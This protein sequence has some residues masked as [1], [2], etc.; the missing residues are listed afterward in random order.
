MLKKMFMFQILLSYFFILVLIIYNL[1]LFL[2]KEFSKRLILIN[3]SL[4]NLFRIL[5]TLVFVQWDVCTSVLRK[6]RLKKF[7]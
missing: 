5:Y 7:H 1:P 6:S 4:V 2:I 3:D